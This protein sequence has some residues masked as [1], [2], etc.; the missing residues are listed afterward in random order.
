MVGVPAVGAPKKSVPL[1]TYAFTLRPLATDV[2]EHGPSLIDELIEHGYN[3]SEV[4]DDRA[5][6][7]LLPERWATE[8]RARGIRQVFD[9]HPADRGVRDFEGVKMVDGMPHCS[10]MPEQLAVINRPTKLV[11]SEPKVRASAEEKAAYERQKRELDEFKAKIAERNRYT[12][13][14]VQRAREGARDPQKTRWEC[15]AQA[16]K[17][18][19]AN[20]PASAF[21]T[22]VP[23]I[24]HPPEKV[25]APRCCTQRTITIQERSR[26]SFART[27]S[28]GAPSGSPPTPG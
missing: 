28:G 22:D 13:R 19:C 9:L 11:L 10:A 20:C 4:A 7:Y 14:L 1:L 17:V 27:S 5:W 15:P 21:L 24:E 8:L 23:E 18:K 6:S 2:A 16:G 3:V 12:F 26:P 25:T